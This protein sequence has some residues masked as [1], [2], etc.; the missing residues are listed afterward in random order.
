M[1]R[2]LLQILLLTAYCILPTAVFAAISTV[3]SSGG[4]YSSIKLTSEATPK[5][6]IAYFDHKT[7]ELRYSYW[8][9]TQWIRTV[10]E[11]KGVIGYISLSLD[12][13]NKPRISYY[14]NISKNNSTGSDI[15][16][17]YG[18]YMT[19]A[20][21]Y[22]YC[23]TTTCLTPEDW[24]KVTV[25]Q[26]GQSEN[27]HTG[28]FSSLVFDSSGNPRIAY[29]DYSH[30]VDVNDIKKGALKLAYCNSGCNNTANWSISTVDT[31][32]GR[33]A[34]MVIDGSNKVMLSYDA[35]EVKKIRYAEA[36]SPFSLWTKVDIVTITNPS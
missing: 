19:G 2:R 27:G 24:T 22:A 11:E 8:N 33:S 14:H 23:S 6:A 34:S 31:D 3:D 32:G 1:I 7:G 30:K 16:G 21:K 5:P 10:V 20:L 4:A 13:G 25:T 18:N 9:G 29:Y 26:I 15:S 28:G 36:S 35:D 12:S 17:K